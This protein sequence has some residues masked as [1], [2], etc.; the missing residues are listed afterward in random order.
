M[1]KLIKTEKNIVENVLKGKGV[2]RSPWIKLSDK[3]NDSRT[4]FL[5]SMI[6]LYLAGLIRYDIEHD[7]EISG[8]HKEPRYKRYVLKLDKKTSLKELKTILKEG[9]FYN[10]KQDTTKTRRV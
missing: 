2:Y 3:L 4:Q 6:K 5:E 10:D 8:P 9:K 1:I 7:I